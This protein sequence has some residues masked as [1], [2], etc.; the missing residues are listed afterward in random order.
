MTAQ[1]KAFVD[2]NYFLYT[3]GIPLNALCAGL[4]VVAGGTGMDHTVRALRRFVKLWTDM[5]YDNIII[6]TGQ[7]SKPGDVKSNSPLIEEAQNLGRRM[8][9]LMIS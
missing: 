8:V 9:D 2:R 1:M 5:P 4:I 6:L 3:H 7:A